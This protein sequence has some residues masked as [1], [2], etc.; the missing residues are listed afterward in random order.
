MKVGT[1]LHTK[2]SELHTNAVVLESNGTEIKVLT[3]FGN[4]L[5]YPDEFAVSQFFTIPLWWDEYVTLGYEIQ[6]VKV[7]L[8]LHITKLNAALYYLDYIQTT[9]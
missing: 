7:R 9:H 1:V 3:D 4:V 8:K 6:P 5:I 2:N